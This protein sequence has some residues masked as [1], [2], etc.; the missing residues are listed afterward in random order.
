MDTST[1]DSSG[2]DAGAGSALRVAAVW[3]NFLK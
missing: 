3:Q 1:G 2:E